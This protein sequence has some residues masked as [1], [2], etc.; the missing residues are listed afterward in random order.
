MCGICGIINLKNESDFVSSDVLKKMNDTLRHRGPDDSGE[1][2][3]KNAGLAHRRLS[4]I[5]LSAMGRQPMSNE[6]ESVWITFNG[7]IYNFQDIKQ[8]LINKGHKFKSNTDTEVIVHSYEEWGCGCVNKF[9]G[10]FAFGIYDFKKNTLFLARDRFG[11]KP[12]YYY[13]KDNI[14]VFASEI[15]AIIAHP[16]VKKN[17]DMSSL[18]KYLFFEYVPEPDSIFENISKLPGGC[19][20]YLSNSKIDVKKYWNVE[21]NSIEIT[22][23]EALIKTKELLKKSISARLISDVPL[24][25]FLSGGIDSSAIVGLLAE[26]I[27][28]KNIKTFSIAFDEKS[29]DES[30]YARLVSK[31]FGTDHREEK[32]HPKT[33]IDILPEIIDKLD[34][35][36]ADNSIIPTYLLSKFTRKHVTVALGGDGGDELFAGYD[37]FIAGWLFKEIRFPKLL[38]NFLNIIVSSIFPVSEKNISLDFKIKRTISGLCYDSMLRNQVWLG[39]FN[40]DVQSFLLTNPVSSN[41]IIFPIRNLNSDYL[42]TIQKMI[43]SYIKLYMQGDILTKVDRASMMNSLEVRAPFL[44][45]E[46]AEFVNSLPDSFKIKFGT[47]K[48]LLKKLTAGVLPDAIINRKKKG[49]GIPLSGWLKRE[50]RELLQDTLNPVKIKNEGIFKPEYVQKLISQHLE[51]KKDNRKELWTLLSFQLWKDRFCA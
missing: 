48:Y 50:L 5:D 30:E 32:L 39:A 16:E 17:I 27:P 49:F 43:L 33:M 38:I 23:E 31:H 2:I 35:P 14:F 44:D 37:P 6:D 51:N 28:A 20:L 40:P 4:I 19:Y 22:E 42:T 10:M 26:M 7:E 45:F 1:Y 25:V 46:L 13:L 15:K 41:E 18:S 11:K 29:F 21:F 34:E 36:F 47:R 8:I 24:G 3:N 12:L 9:N